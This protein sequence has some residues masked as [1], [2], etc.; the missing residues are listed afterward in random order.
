MFTL[1]TL[2]Y[3][4]IYIHTYIHHLVAFS[5]SSPDGTIYTPLR[6]IDQYVREVTDFFIAWLTSYAN[7]LAT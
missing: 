7:G 3:M 5:C 6:S 2:S 4:Y 1:Q